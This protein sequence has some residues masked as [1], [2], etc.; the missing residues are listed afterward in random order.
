MAANFWPN[1]ERPGVPLN[2]DRGDD[3]SRLEGADR[4]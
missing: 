3:R 4:K 1:P 2:P